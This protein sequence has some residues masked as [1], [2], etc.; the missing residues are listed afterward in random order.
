M[1]PVNSGYVENEGMSKRAK[2]AESKQQNKNGELYEVSANL[3]RNR[4]EAQNRLVESHESH[5]IRILSVILV[6]FIFIAS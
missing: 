1:E 4:S 3:N 5:K 6:L 2:K